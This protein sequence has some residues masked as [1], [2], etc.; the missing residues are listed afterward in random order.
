MVY[1]MVILLLI[2][3]ML[4]M[5]AYRCHQE[6]EHLTRQVKSITAGSHINL[7]SQLRTAQFQELYQQLD[8]LLKV[9][10]EERYQNQK[11]EKDLKMT[12]QNMAHDLRTPLTSSIG[13]MQMITHTQEQEERERYLQISLSKMQELKGMLEELFLYTNITSEHYE[14]SREKLCV[15]PLF[16]NTLFKFYDL[17][18]K[19]HQEPIVHFENHDLTFMGNTEALERVFQNIIYNALLHGQGDLKVIQHGTEIMFSN[20]MKKASTPSIEHVFDRFYKAD[21]SRNRTSSGLGLAIVKE[22]VNKMGGSV[23]A[24]IEGDQFILCLYLE[25]DAIHS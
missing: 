8:E 14:L 9:N 10:K 6:L 18:Q 3:G 25:G 19:Q 11:A 17:F 2:S 16:T 22:F 4:L 21:S 7:S 5:Y 1:L 23:K 20:T 13:Y 12:I 15:Y 24:R